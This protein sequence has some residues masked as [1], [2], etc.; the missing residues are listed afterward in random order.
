MLLQHGNKRTI[1]CKVKEEGK[2]WK[3]KKEQTVLF[4]S[5]DSISQSHQ[6]EAPTEHLEAW[7][8]QAPHGERPHVCQ[9][10]PF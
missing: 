9:L 7:E 2:N 6:A 8:R 5:M 10:A 4:L 1:M 3:K